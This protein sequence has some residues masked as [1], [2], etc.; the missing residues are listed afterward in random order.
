MT[1]WWSD[2]VKHAVRKKKDMYK[3]A[4]G[5]GSDSLGRL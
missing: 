1:S 3:K 5:K 2:E 4:L